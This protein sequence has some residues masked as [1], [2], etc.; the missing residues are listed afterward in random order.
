[1]S[2]LIVLAVALP[3][4]AAGIAAAFSGRPPVQ[5]VVSVVALGA[6]LVTNATLLGVVRREGTQVVHLGGWEPPVGISMVADPF[7]MMLAV[8]GSVV[9]LA[10]LLYAIGQP[11]TVD[12]ARFFHPAYLILAAGVSSS[13]LAGDLFNLFVSFEV[14]LGASYVLITLGG[15]A[16]QVRHGMT[17]VV[18]NLLASTLFLT[19]VGL[20]YAATGTVHLADLV[21]RLDTVPD[22]LR[23]ALGMLLLVAFGIKAAIFPLFSW[24]PDSYPTA[25]TPITAVFAGLLTKVGVYAIVRTQTLLFADTSGPSPLLLTM[26]VLTMV[27]GV[28][29]A[30][31]QNDIKRILSFHIVSQIGY[32]L[33]G[34]GLLTVTGLAAAAFYMVHHILVKGSLFLVGGLVEHAAGSAALHRLGGLVR[35][36]PV[37]AALFGVA[38]MGL[39]GLPPSSGFVAKLSLADAGLAEGQG[40]VVGVSLAV[41]VLT[42]FSMTKVWTGAFWGLPPEQE[43]G[44]VT[45]AVPALRRT[46]RTMLLATAALVATTVAVAAGAAPLWDLSVEAARA[47]DAGAYVQAV[48]P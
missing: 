30:M 46:P 43:A 8:V 29:G 24:L 47:L 25:A 36:T 28:L 7:A 31:S 10:V 6:T 40:L 41:S 1:M 45:A 34:L 22:G 44:G 48:L 4:G 2:A 11:G 17:Y 16:D 15:R 5:R 14:M 37:L 23:M 38:A 39:A 9:V 3:L 18:I 21:A 12:E 35:R 32:M 19:A 13:F 42:L 26:A 27:V 20:V 33:M